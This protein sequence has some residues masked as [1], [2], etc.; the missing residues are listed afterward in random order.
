SP[1]KSDDVAMRQ[2]IPRDYMDHI[3]ARLRESGLIE[4]VRGRGGGFRLRREPDEIS[5]WDVF[6]AVEDGLL[7]VQCLDHGQTCGVE[8][9]CTTKDAWIEITAAVRGSLC[10]IRLS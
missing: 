9:Q 1:A 4:S 5:V 6:C 8:R 3:V 2:G 7:P 10:A